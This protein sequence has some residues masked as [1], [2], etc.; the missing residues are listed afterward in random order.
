M[1]S[2]LS[3][4]LSRYARSAIQSKAWKNE[5]FSVL[6]SFV[7]LSKSS[8]SLSLFS[9]PAKRW[10]VAKILNTIK[11]HKRYI[12][13]ANW[14]ANFHRS[15]SLL[16][17]IKSMCTSTFSTYSV[18]ND[19]LFEVVEDREIVAR[20]RL[21][22]KKSMVKLTQAVKKAERKRRSRQ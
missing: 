6:V 2:D 14:K 19:H 15:C 7:R 11:K 4:G 18:F 13:I 12:S 3:E 9:C 22:N 1:S 5:Y 10:L 16:V 17:E 20:K 8:F 21:N